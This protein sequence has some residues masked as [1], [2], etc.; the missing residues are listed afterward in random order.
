MDT[1]LAVLSFAFVATIT[2]GPNNLMV[3]ASGVNYGYARTVPHMLGITVGFPL[4][5]IAV[6]LG[7]ASVFDRFPALHRAIQWVAIL[8]L[9]YLAWRIANAGGAKRGEA[10]GR[11]LSFLGAAAFQ[12]VNPKGW[13]MALA[14]VPLFTTVGGNHLAEVGLIAALFGLVCYP[15]VS[16][17]CLFGT[18]MSR[19]LEDEGWRRGFNIAMALLLVASIVPTIVEEFSGA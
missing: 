2:P 14:S 11:P 8:Y 16:V 17:W 7:L 1:T 6:G 12:W 15:C 13:A 10:G 9:F 5:V 18:A 3:L 4:M 19:F